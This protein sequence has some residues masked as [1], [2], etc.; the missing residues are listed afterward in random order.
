MFFVNQLMEGSASNSNAPTC[1]SQQIEMYRSCNH[2]NEPTLI[3]FESQAKNV[4]TPDLKYDRVICCPY[5]ILQ[6]QLGVN[7]SRYRINNSIFQQQL[8]YTFHLNSLVD[9]HLFQIEWLMYTPH[10]QLSVVW[11]VLE[12][13]LT[14]KPGGISRRGSM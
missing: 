5:I 11:W 4:G 6:Q 13:A 12:N 10:C 9:P 3:R 1:V 7:L 14:Y 8:L 2:I